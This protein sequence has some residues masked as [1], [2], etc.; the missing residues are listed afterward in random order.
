MNEADYKT[1]L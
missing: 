1:L